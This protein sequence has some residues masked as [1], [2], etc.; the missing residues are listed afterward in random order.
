MPNFIYS[1]TKAA[2]TDLR[3]GGWTKSKRGESWSRAFGTK[4][5]GIAY[6]VLAMGGYKISVDVHS[7]ADILSWL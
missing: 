1:N 3:G 6:V 7:R 5:V 4:R 2:E